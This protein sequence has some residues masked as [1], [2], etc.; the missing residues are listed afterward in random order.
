MIDGTLPS[1]TVSS[2]N[3]E[4]RAVAKTP[5][6]IAAKVQEIYDLAKNSATPISVLSKETAKLLNDP[7][8]MTVDVERISGEVMGLLIKHGWKK[9]SA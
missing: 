8:W 1:V 4:T 2:H 7:S 9:P 3:Q 6:E 5:Q